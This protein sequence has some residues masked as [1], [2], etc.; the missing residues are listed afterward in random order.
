MDKPPAEL[1]IDADLVRGLL[2]DQAPELAGLPL[3]KVGEGWDNEI[4]RVGEGEA[5]RVPRRSAGAPLIAHEQRWLPELA[6]RLPLPIPVPRVAGRPTPAFP[7]PWSVVPWFEGVPLGARPGS[8]RL[9]EALGAFLRALHTPAP[10]EAPANPFRGVPLRERAERFQASLVALQGTLPRETLDALRD[11]C[12][13]LMSRP[14]WSGP[15]LWLHGDL[16]PLNLLVRGEVLVAVIDFGDLTRGDPA[17]DL[18]VAW[19]A[20]EAAER[21]V[22]RAA[23]G[24][25]DD[26]TWARAR[27]WALALG[28]AIL[29]RADD[30]PELEAIARATL[31]RAL[32]P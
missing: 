3:R 15:P 9:A 31:R 13:A 10:A 24:P 6:A 23:R 28:A 1:V 7:W 18:A 11:R 20:F 21:S 14:S 17:P 5:L 32:G 26:D 16:H 8:A 4:W 12:T 2:A 29:A 25:L 30:T 27:G 19:M 22:F